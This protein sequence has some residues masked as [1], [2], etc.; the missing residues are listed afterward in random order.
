M[1]AF[2]ESKAERGS[3]IDK[4]KVLLTDMDKVAYR[5]HIAVYEGREDSGVVRDICAFDWIPL[6]LQEYD[7]I[8]QFEEEVL[9]L[10]R[11]ALRVK[12]CLLL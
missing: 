12:L 4:L 6:P 7:Y 5:V 10:S 11:A 3:A 8:T 2:F 1:H 9:L